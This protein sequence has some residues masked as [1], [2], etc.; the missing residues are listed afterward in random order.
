VVVAL[1]VAAATSAAARAQGFRRIINVFRPVPA[2]PPP[3]AADKDDTDETDSD[4]TQSLVLADNG[5]LRRKLEL[6]RREIAGERYTDAARQLAQFLQDPE[7]RDFFLHRDAE[8]RGGR[9][10]QAEVRQLLH[11][12]PA[13]GLAAYR[14][15]VEPVAR[16]RL[17]AA[18]AQGDEALLRDVVLRFP[19]TK[20]ADEALYR[21]SHFLWDHGRTRAAAA[22]LERLRQDA[23]AAA[24][25]E[26]G[27][28]ML[29]AVCWS[30]LGDRERAAAAVAR[31]RELRPPASGPLSV[32]IAGVRLPDLLSDVG[33][34][35]LLQRAGRE[36][37]QRA[38]R[39]DGWWT[40]RGD[41]AR[42]RVVAAQAPFLAPRWSV[43]V[44]AD[45]R[46]QLAIDRAAQAYAQGSG[47][48]LPLL[49][50]LVV[51]DLVLARTAR[52]VAALELETG[53]CLWRYPADD[54]DE[55]IGLDRIVWQEPAGGALAADD[56]CVYLIDDDR[57]GSVEGGARTRNVLSAHEYVRGRQGNLRWQVGGGDGGAEPRLAGA[58]FLGPPLAWYG[59]LYLLA[60]LKGAVSLV[61]LDR[62]SG[63]RAWSQDLALVE[64]P[65]A[66]DVLRLVGGATPSISA[67]EIIVCPTSGGAVVAVDLTTQSLL[68]AY[69][70]ARQPSGGAVP[71]ID[72]IESAPRVDQFDRWLD[73]T[74]SIA[75]DC[76]IATPPESREIHCLDLH[77]GEPLW[78]QPRGEG[79]F[80]ACVTSAHVAV[81][82]RRQMLA[83]RLSD[84]A[85][86]WTRALPG[87]AYP[88]GRGVFT[89]ERYFLPLTTAS[90]LEIDLDTGAVAGEF[91]SPRERSAG[92]L[93]WHKGRFISQGPFAL[94]VFDE[95]DGLAASVRERLARDPRDPA[96]LVR[97]GDLELAGG[98][99]GPA[100]AAFRTA[101][102]TARSPR[103]K[104]KLVS[105]LLEGV[106]RN[107]LDKD[108][109]SRELDGL[110]G[111]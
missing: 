111:P 11:K 8:R 101:H 103:T 31:L 84:G 49:S 4:G 21:L 10:F 45:P 99:I 12:L 36:G 100:I 69:R 47:T 86:A 24:P 95:R 6:V 79:M 17:T 48:S 15:Q 59:R 60:E 98:R 44:S 3:A 19:E 9:G 38:D 22:C 77:S 104:S 58:F 87:P 13:E 85:A 66:D 41:A 51:G 108:A 80:V 43:A 71:S 107:L 53:E 63:H 74:V 81:A 96:A 40:F 57:F 73:G 14:A 34:E 70:Y 92:N 88:A 68:W 33:I 28:S 61:V 64:E 91:R 18:V 5:D 46:T 76:V 89:G 102:E 2:A 16:T 55:N 52:G 72:E 23:D 106:R 50:P 94:E 26:P 37:Q 62:G 54:G 56:E 65:I 105:A 90:V 20:A 29:T 67:D 109:L 7:I 97:L 25:F 82:G 42:N 78:T 39:A 110:V 75:G 83:L 32:P 35:D 1:A 27:L 93:I 30:R